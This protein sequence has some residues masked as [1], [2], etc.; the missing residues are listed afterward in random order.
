ME[1]WFCQIW[2]HNFIAI[3]AVLCAAE[4][5]ITNSYKREV[6]VVEFKFAFLCITNE[7]DLQERT[8]Y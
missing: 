4:M 5:L 3:T 8:C 2:S 6:V 7:V 1:A